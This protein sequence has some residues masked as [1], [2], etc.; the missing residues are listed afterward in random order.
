MRGDRR[1]QRAFAAALLLSVSGAL[2]I[3]LVGALAVQIQQAFHLSEAALGFAVAAFFGISWVTAMPGGRLADRLGW[4][5][6]TRASALVLLVTLLGLALGPDARWFAGS[7][8]AAGVVQS[9]AV[10]T[11]NL[12]LVRD[13]PGAQ[14]GVLFGIKQSAVPLA[15]LFAGASLPVVALTVGWRWAFAG[16]MV[17]PLAVLPFARGAATPSHSRG[18]PRS[19]RASGPLAGIAFASAMAAL[20]VG[21]LTGFL[22]LSAVDTGISEAAAG[23]MVV[24]ASLLTLVMRTALG[25]RQDRR[26][27]SWLGYTTVLI[28]IGCVGLLLLAL[29]EPT[30]HWAGAIIAYAAGW[31]WPGL[32]HYG[33]SRDNADEPAWATG[34]L[35]LGL[36]A[37]TAAGP[38]LFGLS[39]ERLGFSASWLMAAVMMAVGGGLFLRLTAAHRGDDRPTQ[40]R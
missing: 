12:A 33:I 37:G 4:E 9:L 7:L 27:G 10:P 38:A 30:L 31:G 28:M 3:M 6:A 5:S 8:L 24:G 20:P 14:H 13:V 32:V 40:V 16:A 18:Q 36:T 34:V 23:I 11:A 19:L 29:R 1:A 22:V 2:P 21:A 35:R 15:G 26:G 25:W 17:F 39:V